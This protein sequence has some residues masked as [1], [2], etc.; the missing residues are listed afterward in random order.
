M[1]F[2]PQ[3]KITPD[4]AAEQK[5]PVYGPSRPEPDVGY[6][7][8]KNYK[9]LHGYSQKITRDLAKVARMYSGREVKLYKE[10]GGERCHVCTNLATGERILSNCKYCGG[11]GYKNKWEYVGR[12]YTYTDFDPVYKV[13]TP[14]GNTENPNGTRE[15][16]IIVGAPIIHDQGL[17]IF[18]ES[19]EIYKVYD[20][21]PHI[22]ALRGDVVTQI[23]S[24]TRITPGA[25]EYKL[26]DW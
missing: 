16:I 14:A 26:I 18:V 12:Y 22:V 6:Q 10:A 11:T 5:A 8:F 21:E 20:A 24:T 4:E 15:N 19:K 2:D 3:Q 7:K 17:I 23:A 9:Y 25:P 1:T 13:A